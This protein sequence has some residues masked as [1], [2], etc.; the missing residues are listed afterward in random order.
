MTTLKL[1]ADDDGYL[2]DGGLIVSS[3]GAVRSA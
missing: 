2:R 3:A 1:E